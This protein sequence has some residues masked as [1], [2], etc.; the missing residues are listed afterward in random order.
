MGLFF[1]TSRKRKK[2]EKR[3]HIKSL[4]NGIN[5]LRGLHITSC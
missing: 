3:A 4:M 2:E 5:T 1:N